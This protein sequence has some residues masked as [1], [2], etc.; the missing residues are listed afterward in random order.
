MKNKIKDLNDKLNDSNT[1][2]LK[3]K[4]SHDLND[5]E[6]KNE[7]LKVEELKNELS[8]AKKQTD[9][10]KVAINEMKINYNY[11]KNNAEH[12]KS[13]YDNL[14]KSILDTETSNHSL[15]VENIKLK[16][17]NDIKDQEIIDLKNK[18]MKVT[19]D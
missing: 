15:T 5:V 1:Q 6:L 3:I 8:I 16:K 7:K 10:V 9:K 2:N 14:K 4:N 12:F 11:E 18:I 19:K 17:Y 13:M